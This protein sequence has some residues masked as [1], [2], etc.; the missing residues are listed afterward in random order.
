MRWIGTGGNIIGQTVR[1]APTFVTTC[2]ARHLRD[3]MPSSVKLVVLLGSGKENVP[4][5]M[6]RLNGEPLDR[7][8]KVHYAYHALSRMV[9]H[10]PHPSGG[11]RDSI[12]AFCAGASDRAVDIGVL[13]CRRQVLPAIVAAL[14]V[15]A[16]QRE[17]L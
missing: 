3:G 10:L 6:R 12:K 8:A 4:E 11:N 13:E 2:I 7:G 15:D 5:I 1:A 16:A 9:V 14:N 17:D